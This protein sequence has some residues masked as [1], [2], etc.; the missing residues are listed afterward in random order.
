M[1]ATDDS[2]SFIIGRTAYG[3]PILDRLLT[4]STDVAHAIALAYLAFDA[5]RASVVDVEFPIDV[6]VITDGELRQ[7]RYEPD[8]LAAAHD[9]WQRPPRS[10]RRR[11]PDRMGGTPATSRGGGSMTQDPRP[12]RAA[13][14]RAGAV[15][16][17]VRHARRREPSPTR[18]RPKLPHHTGHEDRPDPASIRQAT[19]S[20]G[21]P[22]S[23]DRSRSPTTPPSMSA[24]TSRLDVP[25]VEIPFV[26]LPGEVLGYLHPSRYC[27]SDLL[28]R[29][30]QQTFGQLAPGFD[31][32]TGI[33]NWIWEH[34]SYVPGS[35]DGSS[36]AVDVIVGAAGVCRDY[37]HLGIGFC[38]ALGTPAR[39]VS[40][41]AVDLEPPDFH[42]FFEAFLDGEWYLFDATRMA[43][44]D[45]LVRI[46]TGRDAADVAFAAIVGAASSSPRTSSSST[47]T[48]LDRTT[49][50]RHQRWVP[51][52]DRHETAAAFPS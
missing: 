33:C 46:A 43:P 4:P 8:D 24:L 16:V 5:T 36:T 38:R 51:P 27:Q 23:P 32:V 20:S 45:G 13:L 3:K 50:P 21:P 49:R 40:G 29:F 48:A 19:T 26:E 39:Y 31:R 18:R 30:A 12:L 25:H 7:H 15:A 41:Y 10:R 11:A 6:V 35:T 42:G 22:S 2:P 37:A 9:S 52:D 34:L 14:R 17:R 1:T 47:W 44:L 28:G